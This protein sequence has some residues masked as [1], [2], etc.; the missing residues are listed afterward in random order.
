M[1]GLIFLVLMQKLWENIVAIVALLGLAGTLIGAIVSA[2]ITWRTDRP[3][4]TKM[5]GEMSKMKEDFENHKSENIETFK[6]IRESIHNSNQDVINKVDELK[7]Y[8]LHSKITIKGD[9]SEI[10][11]V[12]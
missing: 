4:L 2:Y 9:E 7:M 10:R 12:K 11:K 3:R 5:E 6:E 1:D 8:L